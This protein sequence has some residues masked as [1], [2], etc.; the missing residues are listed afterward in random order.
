MQWVPVLNADDA[1]PTP[2]GAQSECAVVR[3]E[4]ELLAARLA[5]EVGRCEVESVE[6]SKR[7]RHWL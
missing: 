4:D 7:R 3:R 1:E 2:T 6:R 5:P